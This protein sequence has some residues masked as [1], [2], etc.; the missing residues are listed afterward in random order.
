MRQKLTRSPDVAVRYNDVQFM[1][2][3]RVTRGCILVGSD[4]H[5]LA[6]VS[7]ECMVEVDDTDFIPFDQ[8]M[9]RVKI[10]VLE[11]RCMY[12]SQGLNDPHTDE[13]KM[14]GVRRHAFKS[15]QNQTRTEIP[16]ADIVEFP[17]GGNHSIPVRDSP[18]RSPTQILQ[19]R[20]RQILE[21]LCLAAELD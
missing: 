12:A 3:E 16:L 14:L 13:D 11:T 19:H 9:L 8:H 18:E 20:S 21:R 4:G 17:S 5:I 6:F 1:T 7:R 15:Q 2:A 10:P